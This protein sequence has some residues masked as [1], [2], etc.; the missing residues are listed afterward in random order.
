MQ[1][2][3]KLLLHNEK[4]SFSCADKHEFVMHRKTKV[5]LMVVETARDYQQGSENGKGKYVRPDWD[6]YFIGVAREVAKRSTCD[7]GRAGCVI[8]KDRRIL[9]TGYAGSPVGQPHCDEVGH[10]MRDMFDEQGNVSKHCVRTLHAEENAIIQAAKFGIS[11]DGATIYCKMSP[12]IWCTKMLVNAG[13]K[14]VVCEKRYHASEICLGI[15]K[16]AGIELIVLD[17]KLEEYPNQ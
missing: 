16:D 9:T 15:L 2:E 13:I 5:L 14:R 8:V 17:D 11:L 7:R 10:L 12:C 4:R 3:A 6:S 1:A